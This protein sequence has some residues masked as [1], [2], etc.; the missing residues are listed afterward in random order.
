MH[1]GSRALAYSAAV[2]TMCMASLGQSTVPDA[3]QFTLILRQ[4]LALSSTTS[5]KGPFAGVPRDPSI[6]LPG[7]RFCLMFDHEFNCFFETKPNKYSVAML[8][9]NIA[10][11]VGA[12]VP[13]TWARSIQFD[14]SHKTTTFIDPSKTIAIYVTSAVAEGDLPLGTHSVT[15][16]VRRP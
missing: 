7:A 1:A 12:S 15:L 6:T 8:H 10:Q 14:Q 5:S 3:R 9:E 4:L 13:D 2:L 16:A 11:T